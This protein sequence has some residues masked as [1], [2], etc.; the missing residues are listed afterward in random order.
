M[1]ALIIFAKLPVPGAVKTRLTPPLAPQ[2]AAQ[3][4]G[5]MLRDIV[6]K[7]ARLSELDHYLY[8]E[9]E[10]GADTYF[11]GLG[12][13]MTCLPQQGEG[14]GERMEEAFSRAF[15][16]GYRS[17]AIIGTDSPDL[18]HRYIEMAYQ[19]LRE[20]DDGVV[21]GPSEDG[22]YYL[23]AMNR[24]HPELFRDIPW[25]SE[26]VLRKSLENA[27]AEEIQV[28]LLPRWYDV[29]TA[30]DL[31]RPELLDPDNGAPLTRDFLK[32]LHKH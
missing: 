10:A 13:G 31:A 2:Q 30:E 5:C 9:E 25:S 28:D 7:A 29:D 20:R 15:A 21:F 8:Y 16:A 17:V 14:L 18:P 1:N 19:R 12:E 22:G 11:A 32:A 3:L 4:Y 24:L 6:A 27:A 26:D 23:L